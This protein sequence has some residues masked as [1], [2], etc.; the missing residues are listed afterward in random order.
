MAKTLDPSDPTPYFYDAIQKQT[1]NRPVEALQDMEKAIELNDNRAVYRSRLLLDGDLA[2]RSASL[3]RIY[4]DLGFQELALVEGWRSVNNDPANFSAHR[5]L[6]DS[7]AAL[8]RHEIARVSELLQSQL[9][10]PIN[11]TPDPAPARGKQ[12]VGHIGRRPSDL[13]FNDSIRCSSGTGWRCRRTES[14]GRTARRGRRSSSPGSI[15]RS[16]L[17]AGQ[18]HFRTDGFR[19]N[20]DLKDDDLQ[21]LRAMESSPRTSVQAEYRQGN[22]NTG[23]SILRCFPEDFSRALRQEAGIR[24]D[25][26]RRPPS[27]RLPGSDLIGSFM[28]QELEDHLTS[29]T[30]SRGSP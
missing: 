7:Y 18:Y 30:G 22:R 6:A 4:N 11:I 8:P 17:S 15:I 24:P 20:D 14:S 28:L 16:P 2:A 27:I 3:G 25:T 29:I 10:Q 19:E 1:T 12:P 5:F 23:I 21:H 26:I 13:S 9:L